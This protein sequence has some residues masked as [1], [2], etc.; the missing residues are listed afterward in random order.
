MYLVHPL[1]RATEFQ[2]NTKHFY[3]YKKKIEIFM[4][5]KY[6]CLKDI[7]RFENVSNH[8]ALSQNNKSHY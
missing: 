5:S 6:I 1:F 8:H 2:N 7:Q 3:L 4:S